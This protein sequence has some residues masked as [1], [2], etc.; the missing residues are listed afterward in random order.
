M[1]HWFRTPGIAAKATS[2]LVLAALPLLLMTLAE[3][4]LLRHHQS[5]QLNLG[6]YLALLIYIPVSIFLTWRGMTRII[7]PLKQLT[8]HLQQFSGK[9][10]EARFLPV[11]SDDEIGRLSAVFNCLLQE[12]DDDATAL[13]ES[14][15]VY[16]VVTEFSSEVAVW[17]LENGDIRYISPNCSAAFG[18]DAAEFY[19][20]PD[21]LA[22]L[23]DPVD[24]ERWHEHLPGSCSM[25]GA[26]LEL[27]MRHK[28]GSIRYF[29]HHCHRVTDQ[30]GRLHPASCCGYR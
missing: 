9:Q 29:R 26:G 24:Y 20:E 7:R 23:I 10:G 17:Q 14:A 6:L 15:E 13:E 2:L 28:D 12:L 5:H 19:A 18:Y 30:H 22:R 3:L 4:L 11:H 27:Q 8:E 1:V 21:L 16:R 25:G